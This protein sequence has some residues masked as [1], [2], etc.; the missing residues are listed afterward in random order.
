MKRI[1]KI[2]SCLLIILFLMQISGI[3]SLRADCWNHSGQD[4]GITGISG[5]FAG[6][7]GAENPNENANESKDPDPVYLNSG[8]Y[9]YSKQDLFIPSRGMPIEIKR[10]Y[11]SQK[12]V[13]GVL[14]FGWFLSCNVRLKR[15]VNNNIVIIQGDGRKDEYLR[16]YANDQYI[17]P[18]GI[19]SEL[20]Q[21]LDGTFTL[22][23]KNG[24]KYD[25]DINGNLSA[26]VDRNNNSMSFTY[27]QSK[28]PVVGKS[29]YFVN[30]VQGLIGYEYKLQK[31]TDTV[32]RDI[33]FI[34]NSNGRLEKITDFTSREI[35]YGY[36]SNDNLA[37]VQDPMGNTMYYTY[38]AD[39]NLETIKDKKDQIYL[40]NQYNTSDKVISQTYGGY[41]TTIDYDEENLITTVIDRRGY[42][43]ISTFDESGNPIQKEVFTNNVRAGDPLSY[44]TQTEYNPDNEVRKITYPKGN[45]INK[46]YDAKGNVLK[47]TR[48]PVTGSSDPDIV[49]EFTYDPVFNFIKTIKDPLQRVTTYDY[50]ND[51]NIITITYPEVD[52]QIPEV[53]FTYNQYGQLETKTDP[54]G[55]IT[56]FEYYSATGYLHKT[57][58]DFGD[59]TH[60]NNTTEF[61]YDN[62]GNILTVTDALGNVTTMEY[63]A[64]NRLTKT[65]SPAPFN[66]QTKYTYDENNNLIKLEKQKNAAA[67]E[68][69]LTEYEYDNLDQLVLTKQYLTDL[70]IYI[71]EFEYDGSQN[72]TKIIDAENKQTNYVYDERGLL[73][74][75]TDAETNIT[76]YSYDDNGNLEEIQDAKTNSTDYEY[77]DFNRLLKTIYPDTSYEEFTYDA[78]SNLK[79]KRTRKGD[80]LQYSYDELNRIKTKTYPNTTAVDY[81]YDIASRLTSV[82][83]ITS[84][85]TSYVYDNLNRVTSVDNGQRVVGYEYDELGNRIKLTYP[86]NTYVTYDYDELNR[87]TDVRDMTNSSIASYTYD[88]LSRRTQLDYANLAQTTYNY[89]DLSRLTSVLCSQSSNFSYT[90]DKV[91]N[92]KSMTVDS[93]DVHSYTYDNIYQ[94]TDVDYPI[95]SAFSDTT[96]NYDDLGNRDTVVDSITT[97]Y[98]SNDVNQYTDVGLDSITHDLN[99]NLTNDSNNTYEYDYENWTYPDLVDSI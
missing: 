35:I 54:N 2:T 29:P 38:Y 34:Y 89:D 26:I 91:G 86:D 92:R 48:S 47:I 65:I 50:D 94:L 85:V 18:A 69:Q 4:F 95:S 66:Y 80:T 93:T 32:G 52:S 53:T 12:D 40:V 88:I 44:L 78:N 90:Y 68:W 37:S 30:Q 3:Q 46:E 25:F 49:T 17:P 79:S 67:A 14:G 73:Y 97:S 10:Y 31:I 1:K 19:Y 60:F 84:Q 96:Y 33:D 7:L 9:N 20:D 72:R 64:L 13:N 63:D 71:T 57:I 41:T 36:D 70:D 74:T 61:T 58:T 21:N 81:D 28:E 8:E 39:H 51:G 24:K 87:L 43:S 76:T 6:V 75:V 23:E 99:G 59:I 56:K 77:D 16:D 15:L 62:R 22:T 55:V 5:A 98:T 82:T 45:S 42:T 27:S 83:G 11:K